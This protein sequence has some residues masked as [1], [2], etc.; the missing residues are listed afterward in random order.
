MENVGFHGPW[1]PWIDDSR[2]VFHGRRSKWPG[3]QWSGGRFS[4]SQNPSDEVKNV[5][6]KLTPEVKIGLIGFNWI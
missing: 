2:P 4:G 5:G 1:T 3:P 6:V